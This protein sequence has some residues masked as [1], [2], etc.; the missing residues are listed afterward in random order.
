MILFRTLLGLIIAYH[1]T[2]LSQQEPTVASPLITVTTNDVWIDFPEAIDF[3]VVAVTTDLMIQ[4]AKLEYGLE[5]LTCGNVTSLATPLFEPTT[6][7]DLK[8]RWQVLEGNG[9]PPGAHIW[10]RWNL[11]TVTGD[12]VTTPTTT[13]VF[14]DHWFVW[15]TLSQ[16]NL[17]VHWYRGPQDLGQ[18]MLDAGLTAVE[19][20]AADTGL[21]LD[22]PVDLYLYDE[23]FDLQIS[24]PGAPGWAGGVAFPE[25]N[26]VLVTANKDHLDY[27]ADTVRHELGHVV[28][29][30]LT[31][32]CLNAL[33][34][35]LNEGLA[36]VAEGAN[37]N[38]Y[39]ETLTEAIQSDKL[40]SLPQ[41]DGGFSVHTDRALLS[42]A[43]SYSIV[44]YLVDTY[45]PDQM[46]L[47]LQT[48]Q[49]GKTPNQAFQTAY[50]FDLAGLADEWRVAVDAS[51]RVEV[52]QEVNASPT[53][54]ATL[55]LFNPL[56]PATPLAPTEPPLTV[57][58][59]HPT[60]PAP[61]TPT[62]HPLPTTLPTL[63]TPEPSAL[64]PTDRRLRPAL[65]ILVLLIGL[66]ALLVIRSRR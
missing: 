52:V 44:R 50:G 45:G 42:Y 6:H 62:S 48:F 9:I 38:T 19:Q 64:S 43:E 53:A 22:E 27:G 55:S 57:T 33:P 51:P 5:G 1:T 20:L 25:Y 66:M 11:T 12:V 34:T 3:H 47:L 46:L 13:A 8:W 2:L 15:Q 65:G 56:A 63:P 36:M 26:I 39:E 29:G 16:E 59:V 23:P 31:F 7:L 35:W 4:S 24:V 49:T 61:A 14:L 54:V 37:A 10:W 41:L 60:V 17:T 30:R 18:Q 21:R 28:I 58:A 32:N 40:L